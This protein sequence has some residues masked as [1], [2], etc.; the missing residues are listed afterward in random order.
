MLTRVAEKDFDRLGEW[1]YGLAQERA[2][3]SYPS[4]ADG[5]K[6]RED[7]FKGERK[8]LDAENEEILLAEFDGQATGW[9][10]WY[11]L[12]EDK[13]AATCTCLTASHTAETL[14]ELTRR[15]AAM[16]PGA[17]LTMG[18]PAENEAACHWAEANGFRLLDAL[19]DTVCHL[20]DWRKTAVDPQIALVTRDSFDEFRRLHDGENM[21]WSSERIL[22]ALER[23]RVFV[24][25]KEGRAAAAAYVMDG[26]T[27]AELFG[28]D[29]EAD[30]AV[31]RALIQACAT[32][33][34]ARGQRHL[35][36]FAEENETSLLRELGFII[37]GAYRSYSK[38]M[39]E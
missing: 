35:V 18:F 5:I 9:I 30:D 32:D 6:T 36:Y 4:Y 14:E 8:G 10:H 17:E 25:R 38:I 39:G 20:E 34:K 22:S 7:F 29:G 15:V 23:W 24:Y 33:E 19:T 37:H 12:P 3:A 28:I 11:Y 2:H 16:A 21:Y 31:R 27:L 1:A 26:E 13:Y